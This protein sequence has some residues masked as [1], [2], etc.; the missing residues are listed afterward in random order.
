M[1]SLLFLLFLLAGPVTFSQSYTIKGSV[2][3]T[4]NSNQLEYAS[5]VLIRAKDSTMAAY[6]RAKSDGSFELKT[7]SAASYMLLI[8][9]PGFADYRDYFRIEESEKV[10]DLGLIPMLTRA[11]ALSEFV[12]RQRQGAIKIKGD[13]TEYSADSFLVKPGA[14]V[15]DLLKKLPG[16]T[17]DSKGKITA[18]GEKVEKILVDGE[19]FFSDDPAVVTKN[20]QSNV[21]DKVQVFDKKS[22]QAEFTGIDDGERTKTINLQLKEDKKK[23]FFGRVS[24]GAG[25][26]IASNS[27]SINGNE[28]NDEPLR[29]GFFENQ[30]M[31]NRFRGKEQISVYGIMSNTGRV[32]LSWA[33]AEKYGSGRGSA[34]YD[35][36]S[37]NMFTMYTGDDDDFG[38]YDGT[39]TG[40]GLPTVWTG[41]LHYANK[42]GKDG[43]RHLSANYRFAR[44]NVDAI[45][46]TLTQ[47]ILP[48]S[49]YYTDEQRNSFN[50]SDRHGADVLYEWKLDSLSTLKFTA[51]GSLT[52]GNSSSGY[53]TES[54]TAGGDLINTGGRS[55]NGTSTKKNLDA[56]L[57]YRRK[58]NKKGR[59]LSLELRESYRESESDNLLLSGNTFYALDVPLFA[60][61]INQKKLNDNVGQT[62]TGSVNYTEPLS[63]KF[64]LELN[65]QLGVSNNKAQRF[66]Y[67]RLPGTDAYTDLDSVYSS[68]YVFDLTTHQGGGGV[69]YVGDKLTASVGVKAAFA[70]FRQGDRLLDTAYTRNY[71]NFFP[72]AMLR[73]KLGQQSAIR[74]NYNG[75]TQ[76]PTIDQLQPLR[77]NT[78][79]LN[80]AIGNPDLEQEF[81]HSISLNYNDY[82]VFTGRYVYL[83]GWGS[84]TQNDI[85][86]SE[87]I[88]A[89]G[90]RVYQYINVDG[91]FTAQLWGGVGQ[92]FKKTK[93]LRAGLWLSA[94]INRTNNFINGLKNENL[95]NNYTLGIQASYAKDEKFDISYQ[96]SF[97]YFQNK[98]TISS[99]QTNYWTF[100]QELNVSVELPYK[101][102]VGTDINWENRQKTAIFDKNNS[103]FTWNAYVGKRFFEKKNLEIRLSVFDIL[104]QNLGYRRTAYQNYISE[105]RYNT[106]RR[107]GMLT[108]IWNFTHSPL[109]SAP[110]EEETTIM[111]GD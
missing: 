35:E 9:F 85:S 40:E 81:N 100:N 65:Y 88:D 30:V 86:R 36:E 58:F 44:R 106:I 103:V 68:D 17:V 48:D 82:K 63:K 105:N 19:E 20:L 95:N 94:G 102:V 101:M 77:Q 74:I 21:V 75:G 80:V 7:D 46:N 2:A 98:A 28:K 62:F 69:K 67:N 22:D 14:T 87:T 39:Y 27:N 97:G 12:L 37:G 41:G 64:F 56:N 71:T 99:Q 54:R 57:S 91:N 66:S 109:N 42:W 84:L 31:L 34:V 61:S 24:L 33:D 43:A 92:E 70:D 93:G 25:P 3:D 73:Y 23:G 79:P 90:R 16:I 10:K 8:T 26:S 1:R 83:G 108:L 104:N 60:D 47:Y 110:Q 51:S 111:T 5:V 107:H 72:R 18:Q 96:P 4:F 78:D 55:T 49:S 29:N 50:T 89:F 76:Q 45:G 32:G 59:T 13:T 53:L 6:T 15:E 11:N 38:N 52:E